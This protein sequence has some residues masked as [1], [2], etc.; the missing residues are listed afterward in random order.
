[1]ACG[2]WGLVSSY[3]SQHESIASIIFWIKCSVNNW[4]EIIAREGEKKYLVPAYCNTRQRKAADIH[5]LAFL[6]K[7]KKE[8]EK[9]LINFLSVN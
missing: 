2:K 3:G 5:S 6:H 7:K 9:S 1:M 8:K 4:L